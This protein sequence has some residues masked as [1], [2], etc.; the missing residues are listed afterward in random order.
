MRL[1]IL[2]THP[3]HYFA[4]LYGELTRQLAS[5][6]IA[7]IGDARAN[8]L[9]TFD[10][11][12]GQDVIWDTPLLDGFEWVQ[13]G[14]ATD[15]LERSMILAHHRIRSATLAWLND[16]APDV[17]MVP[18]WSPVYQSA[19]SAIRSARVPY[20]I[21]PEARVPEGWRP[22]R[23]CVR[24]VFKRRVV[25]HAAAAA[26]IGSSAYDE[27]LRLGMKRE[28]MFDS[29]YSV[30]IAS[31]AHPSGSRDRQHYR[32]SWGLNDETLVFT[33]VGKLV[34]YKQVNQL[35]EAYSILREAFSNSCL[36]IVGAGPLE[37]R[38]RAQ[39]EKL[40][41]EETIR[42]IG[43]QGQNK[44]PGILAASDV[45]VLFSRETWGL[46]VNEAIALG[47]PVIVSRDA[48]SSR[49]LVAHQLSGFR[50]DASKP[51][52]CATAMQACA[53]PELR[54]QMVSN[55]FRMLSGH[56]VPAAA[57]GIIRAA[58]HSLTLTG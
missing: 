15:G 43:F 2:A 9:G 20:V 52:E 38:L 55:G 56:D 40:G 48:G 4:P 50:V 10:P 25:K 42:W 1:G 34:D 27:L 6:Q 33:Y 17:V 37:A 22:I 30:M 11:G 35:I 8:V 16:F 18:G 46:V 19:I 32:G 3:V 41:V 47:K 45:F 7:F 39:A 24:D 21:R 57:R 13:F 54:Q 49:D 23:G 44:L 14:L 12:F 31:K 29:P 26:V 5:V 28:D 36:V 51:G 53:D 58:R